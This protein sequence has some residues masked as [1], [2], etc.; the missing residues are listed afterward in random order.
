MQ[1]HQ[2]TA[3]LICTL[4][5]ELHDVW[6]E[7]VRAPSRVQFAR[8]RAVLESFNLRVVDPGE[9]TTSY[10]QGIEH[11][12]LL[13]SQGVQVLVVYVARWAY[14]T[15]VVAAAMEAGVPVIVWTG[16]DIAQVGIV[17]A[18]AVRGSLDEAGITHSLVYGDSTI[19]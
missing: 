11:G 15:S 2:A 1:H 18:S 10:Q 4:S 17:G 8:A 3:G 13:R 19:P 7:A 14:G 6:G 12:R 16:T 9:F 5:P